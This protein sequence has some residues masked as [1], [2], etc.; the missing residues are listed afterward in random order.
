MRRHG[1]LIDMDGVIYRERQLIP[2]AER[3]MCRLCDT[4]ACGHA[5]GRC[6]VRTAAAQAYS[7]PGSS[8]ARMR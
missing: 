8:S 2:G 5:E 6:P 4:R 3:F 7:S 1:F